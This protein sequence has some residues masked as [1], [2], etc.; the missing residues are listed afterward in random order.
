MSAPGFYSERRAVVWCA[1]PEGLGLVVRGARMVRDRLRSP[2]RV[3]G[4]NKSSFDPY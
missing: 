2:A 1:A 3:A 4:R